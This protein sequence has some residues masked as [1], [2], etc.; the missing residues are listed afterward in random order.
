MMG[1]NRSTVSQWFN[2]NRDPPAEA[3]AEMVAA[4]EKIGEA[5]AQSFI[6]LYPEPIVSIEPPSE[7]DQIS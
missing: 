4:L 7:D 1:I 2:E 5:A 6:M 3:V